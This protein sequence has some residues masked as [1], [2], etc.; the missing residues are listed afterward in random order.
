MFQ[1]E[2][3]WREEGPKALL[4]FISNATGEDYDAIA[5]DTKYDFDPHNIDAVKYIACVALSKAEPIFNDWNDPDHHEAFHSRKPNDGSIAEF[6]TFGGNDTVSMRRCERFDRETNAYSE[7]PSD[8]MY[9]PDVDKYYE[10]INNALQKRDIPQSDMSDVEYKKQLRRDI[11][12]VINA[13]KSYILYAAMAFGGTILF[14]KSGIGV[15]VAFGLLCLVSV[16]ILLYITVR[17][18]VQEF[19]VKRQ[20]RC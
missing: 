14:L 15:L 3:L 20:R 7:N 6:G 13:N 10:V 11:Y 17:D 9:V 19:K 4:E 12:D 16:V 5:Y 1:D 2:N 8:S 18:T